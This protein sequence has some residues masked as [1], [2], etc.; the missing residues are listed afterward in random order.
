MMLTSIL[1]TNFSD[2]VNGCKSAICNF[3]IK[4]L[5]EIIILAGMLF[6]AFNLVKGR[7]AGALV[8]GLV[9][10]ACLSALTS[11]LNFNVLYKLFSTILGSGLLVIIIIFQPEIRDALEK[12]GNGSLK[13][14]MSFADRKRKKEQYYNAIENVCSAVT[15]LSR[16]STG[17]LI[18]IE[19]SILLA[20]ITRTGVILDANVND[21]LLRN[22]FFNRSPLH[23]GAVVISGDKI[24]AAGCF[25][26]LTQRVDLDSSLGTRH[27]AAIGMAERSDAIVIVVSEETGRISV[28]YDFTLIRDVKPTELKLLLRQHLLKNSS[29]V[30]DK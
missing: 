9:V 16:E 28:A 27:R 26:P 15:E 23:D 21:L 6:L 25:L 29:Y 19:R 14:I 11:L 30:S 20:D 5:I 1:D 7:K 4:D 10:L 8:T 3:N 13:G 24:V 2:I 18:V 22:L 17:A 12:I